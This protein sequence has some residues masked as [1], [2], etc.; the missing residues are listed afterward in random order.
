[1]KCIFNKNYSRSWTRSLDASEKCFRFE[2][3]N[4]S[5]NY[6]LKSVVDTYNTYYQVFHYFMSPKCLKFRD[7]KLEIGHALLFW[8]CPN[9]WQLVSKFTKNNS[10]IKTILY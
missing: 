8:K 2:L 1:M 9:K 3:F 5:L 7:A 4:V 6:S 10:D